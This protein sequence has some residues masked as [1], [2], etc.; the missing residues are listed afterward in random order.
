MLDRIKSETQH[1]NTNDNI[2]FTLSMF[3]KFDLKALRREVEY[4][5]FVGLIIFDI[6]T[7]L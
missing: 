7:I 6:I 1:L 5:L 4:N 2:V 3:W